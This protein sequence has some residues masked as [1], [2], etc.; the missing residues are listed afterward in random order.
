M[1]KLNTRELFL[2]IKPYALFKSH[3]LSGIKDD[4]PTKVK[5]AYE[6]IKKFGVP[7]SESGATVRVERFHSA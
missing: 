4:A 1:S 3:M 5:E 6:K 2:I 7:L